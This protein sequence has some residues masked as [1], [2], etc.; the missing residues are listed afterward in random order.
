MTRFMGPRL[1]SQVAVERRA[2]R[3]DH[4]IRGMAAAQRRIDLPAFG[5]LRQVIARFM[6]RKFAACGDPVDPGLVGVDSNDVEAG[7]VKAD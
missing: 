1:G 5:Q 4:R 2:H 7:I 3:N 6:E